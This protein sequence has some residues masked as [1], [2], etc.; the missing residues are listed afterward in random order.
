MCGL[1]IFFSF[2]T[3]K[4]ERRSSVVK[5]EELEKFWHKLS[6]AYVTEESDDP[7]NPNGIVEHKLL[8]RSKSKFI[9]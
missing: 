4:F 9:P 8:W 7:D 5:Q 1:G 2:Y 3:Q 6:L